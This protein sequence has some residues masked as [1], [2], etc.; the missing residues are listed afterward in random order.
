MPAENTPVAAL[1]EGQ[2]AERRW[3]RAR[4]ILLGLNPEEAHDILLV[5]AMGA[6]MLLINVLAEAGATVIQPSQAPAAPGS[7]AVN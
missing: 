6:P 3:K 5:I 2:E 4:Q 7:K 1:P